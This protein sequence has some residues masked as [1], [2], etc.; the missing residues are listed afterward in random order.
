MSPALRFDVFTLFPEVFTPYLDASILQ[1]ARHNGLLEVQPA[2]HPRLDDRQ[3]PRLRR[4]ALR[5]GRRHGDEA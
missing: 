3:T 4:P 1:R 5:R 2:Q